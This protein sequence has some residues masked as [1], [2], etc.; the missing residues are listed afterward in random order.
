MG[1]FLQSVIAKSMLVGCLTLVVV[2]KE[3][4]PFLHAVLQSTADFHIARY[5]IYIALL[6]VDRNLCP[7]RQSVGTKSVH[8]IIRLA[9][10][11]AHRSRDADVLFLP[12]E[13]QYFSLQLRHCIR[14]EFLLYF[15]E[16]ILSS[17]FFIALSQARA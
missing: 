12:L 7:G 4:D 15:S 3:D 14:V 16:S 5:V 11:T 6:D 1:K 13:G 8:N 2:D 17:C 9:P 10:I